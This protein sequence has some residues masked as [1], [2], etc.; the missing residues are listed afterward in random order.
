MIVA[1]LFP[2]IKQKQK[3]AEKQTNKQTPSWDEELQYNY[4]TAQNQTAHRS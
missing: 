3:Q 2:I 4:T 1:V